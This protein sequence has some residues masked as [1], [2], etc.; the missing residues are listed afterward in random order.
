MFKQN[1]AEKARVCVC[2][3]QSNTEKRHLTEGLCGRLVSWA[4]STIINCSPLWLSNDFLGSSVVKNLPAMQEKWAWYQGWEVP[5]EEEMAAHSRTLAWKIPWKEEPGGLQSIESQRV[6]HDWNDLSA[7]TIAWT[8]QFQQWF[9]VTLTELL[10]CTKYY[11][12]MSTHLIGFPWWLRWWRIH[13][14]CRRQ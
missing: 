14:Q 9:Q 10:L 5:L 2:G 6:G 7:R 12:E 11:T 3:V 8:Q 13:L 1:S 4:I